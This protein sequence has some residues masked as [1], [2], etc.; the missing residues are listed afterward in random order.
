MKRST[1]EHFAISFY[2]GEV[3]PNLCEKDPMTGRDIEFLMDAPQFDKVNRSE[4]W[5]YSTAVGTGYQYRVSYKDKRFSGLL[6]LLAMYSGSV[7][8]ADSDRH[9]VEQRL[10]EMILALVREQ[11]LPSNYKLQPPKDARETKVEGLQA[12]V[13]RLGQIIEA[14]EIRVKALESSS[15]PEEPQ[16]AALPST[17]AVSPPPGQTPLLPVI[18]D[19]SASNS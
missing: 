17:P 7:P 12:E 13:S 8:V 10:Y 2:N 6:Q 9:M 16:P 15:E 3:K 1:V 18:P 11:R 5:S 4:V 14:L 19:S